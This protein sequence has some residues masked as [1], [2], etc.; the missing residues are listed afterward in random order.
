MKKKLIKFPAR[1]LRLK[2]LLTISV[3]RLLVRDVAVSSSISISTVD[4]DKQ[5]V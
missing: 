5:L 2:N 1:Y 3:D 4:Y